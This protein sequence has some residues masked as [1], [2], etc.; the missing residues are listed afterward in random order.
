MDRTK[1]LNVRLTDDE[2]R[3]LRALVKHQGLG[4][5]DVIRQYI[6]RAFAEIDPIGRALR[7]LPKD[8]DYAAAEEKYLKSKAKKTK[9]K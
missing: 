5:S 2:D 1:V 6:R 4:V 7:T 9:K 8:F 3:M